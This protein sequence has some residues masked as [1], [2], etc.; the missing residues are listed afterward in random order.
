M[1]YL[2]I[3]YNETGVDYRNYWS[4]QCICVMPTN[5]YGPN[6]N[7]DLETSHVLPALIRKFHLAKLANQGDREAI[8][9]DEHKYG[10]IP[11]EIILSIGLKTVT[12]KSQNNK[13]P[14]QAF[15]TALGERQSQKRVSTC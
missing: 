9:R 15:C 6:D 1:D 12:F 13:F 11:E 2:E 7:F 4:G 14:L 5:L 3:F 10:K 8:K